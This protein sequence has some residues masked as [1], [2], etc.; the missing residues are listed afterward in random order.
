MV[1]QEVG[2]PYQLR[3][4]TGKPILYIGMGEKLSDLGTV[5]S[6]QNGF[7]NPWYG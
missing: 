3:L 7:K 1:I 2:R 5:S 6:R 4:V